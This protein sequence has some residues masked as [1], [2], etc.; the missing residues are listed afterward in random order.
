[1]EEDATSVF[2]EQLSLFRSWLSLRRLD[3][4]TLELLQSILVSGDVVSLDAT[5]SALRTLLRNEI[6]AVLEEASS[7]PAEEKFRVL[8]FFVCAFALAG[9]AERCLAL[10]YEA[11]LLR[12]DACIKSPWLEVSYDEWMTL[13]QDS[14]DN[15]FYSITDKVLLALDLFWSLR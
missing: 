5:R 4:P 11:L 1:M 10:R 8:S 7:K 3:D 13:T 15:G 2:A 6:S 14:F 12:Q 9:D